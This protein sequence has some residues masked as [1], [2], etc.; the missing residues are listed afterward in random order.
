MID[1]SAG[2]VRVGWGSRLRIWEFSIRPN[3]L[4]I[5]DNLNPLT[6]ESNCSDIY[7]GFFYKG[8]PD[9]PEVR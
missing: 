5:P 6:A 9:E 8:R 4:G 1:I 7:K 3:I 2:R